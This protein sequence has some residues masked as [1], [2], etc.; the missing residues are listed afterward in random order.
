MLRLC[1]LF[2]GLLPFSLYPRKDSRRPACLPDSPRPAPCSGYQWH[3][4]TGLPYPPGSGSRLLPSL[5]NWD[6]IAT[7]PPP[8]PANTHRRGIRERLA[9]TQHHGTK[10]EATRFPEPVA[11]TLDGQVPRWGTL[12]VCASNKNP[13]YRNKG[14]H[15]TKQTSF[16]HIAWC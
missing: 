13:P 4:G 11:P 6:G 14:G 5:N 2:P 7:G 10:N 9:P 1:H 12:Q 8:A 16:R 3:R 15:T